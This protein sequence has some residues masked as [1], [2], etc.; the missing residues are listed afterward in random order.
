MSNSTSRKIAVEQFFRA[1]EWI[2]GPLTAEVLKKELHRMS[3]ELEVVDA[4]VDALH[5]KLDQ[6][7]DQ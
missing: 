5:K 2:H 3:E 7:S 6:L 1:I 4:I